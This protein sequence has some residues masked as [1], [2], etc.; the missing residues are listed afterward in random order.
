MLYKEM[1][2]VIFVEDDV[3]KVSHLICAGCPVQ[4][5]GESVQSALQLAVNNDRPRI[6]SLLLAVGA[7]LTP[8]V[9]GL[10]LLQQA[11]SSSNV[12]SAVLCSLTKVRQL[13]VIL[14]DLRTLYPL[15]VG[16]FVVFSDSTAAL[17]SLEKH[18]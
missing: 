16:R 14:L 18:I 1:L 13:S 10:N 12:T 17:S 11:W 4:P 6:L 15:A 3:T 9:N 8:F 5:A 2:D 7:T